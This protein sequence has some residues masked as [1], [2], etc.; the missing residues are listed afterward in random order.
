MSCS[1]YVEMGVRYTNEY[2]D[3]DDPFYSSLESMYGRLLKHLTK[4]GLK[5]QFQKRVQAIVMD[6]EDIGWGFNDN[7]SYLY[8]EWNKG[9]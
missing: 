1:T 8:D 6:T 3:I 7:L 4:H 2:G 9:K 5:D